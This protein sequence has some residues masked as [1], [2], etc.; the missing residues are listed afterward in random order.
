MEVN[1]SGPPPRHQIGGIPVF[2]PLP[3]LHRLLV[4]VTAV[5]VGIAWG[6]WIAQFSTL[7]AAAA[8]GA[9][10]GGLAGVLLG[11]VLLHDFHHRPKPIRVQ[12][13]RH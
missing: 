5:A 4:V 11:F 2:G 9:A 7:P 3:R 12:H 6:V 10:W 1:R 13:R 8:A